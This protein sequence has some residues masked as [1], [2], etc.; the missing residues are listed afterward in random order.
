[1][2]EANIETAKT[3]AENAAKEYA[4]TKAEAERVLAE[5]YA[6]GIVSDEEQA[7]IDD[8][9]DKLAELKPMPKHKMHY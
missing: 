1:M 6:D 8:V 4:N 3:E 5:A 2:L 9:N 7:R